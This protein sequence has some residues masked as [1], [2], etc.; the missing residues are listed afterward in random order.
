MT[1]I[2]ATTVFPY[3]ES[4]SIFSKEITLSP[5]GIYGGFS[6]LTANLS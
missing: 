6:S 2:S 5:E 1:F 3:N 4:L